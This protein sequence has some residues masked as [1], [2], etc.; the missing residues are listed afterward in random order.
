MNTSYIK[1]LQEDIEVDINMETEYIDEDGNVIPNQLFIPEI[2]YDINLTKKDLDIE[3]GGDFQIRFII[4]D[5]LWYIIEKTL[6][7]CYCYTNCNWYE[8]D[9]TKLK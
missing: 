7:K 9:L 3:F 6:F 2:P 1:R 5:Q 4:E 8:I